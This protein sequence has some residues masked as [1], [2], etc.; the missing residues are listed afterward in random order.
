MTDW[1]RAVFVAWRIVNVVLWGVWAGII[2]TGAAMPGRLLTGAAF[3]SLAF[4]H[5]ADI[6]E[7]RTT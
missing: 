7:S 5:L 4:W 1:K 3:L 2:F 6:F